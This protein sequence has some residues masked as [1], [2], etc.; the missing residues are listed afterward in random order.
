MNLRE[1]I[2]LIKNAQFPHTI[3]LGKNDI[4]AEGAKALAEQLKDAK[5][6]H[7]IYLERNNIGAEG[8]KALA[9]QLKDAKV[10]H[11]IG[12]SD[13]DI[14][15]EGA[16]ALVE[17]LKDAKVPLTISL[18]ENDIGAQGAKDLAEQWKDAK[19]PLTIYLNN[20]GAQG[21]KDLAEQWKDAKVSH[22]IGLRPNYTGTKGI[23][24][25][26]EQLKYAKVSH[27]IDLWDN[28]INYAEAKALREL[29]DAPIPQRI[30]GISEEVD[31]LNANYELER[32]FFQSSNEEFYAKNVL[33]WKF[34]QNF[35]EEIYKLFM[36]SF[37]SKYY[38]TI[39]KPRKNADGI[40][41]QNSKIPLLV[42]NGKENLLG[43][44]SNQPLGI[45][46]EYLGEHEIY[47]M[48]VELIKNMLIHMNGDF[49]TNFKELLEINKKPTTFKLFTSNKAIEAYKAGVKFEF[50]K[51]EFLALDQYDIAE[52]KQILSIQNY[53]GNLSNSNNIFI[54]FTI[55]TAI[56]N[57][58]ARRF[59]IC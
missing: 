6:S 53:L 7:N 16:K 1:A 12:L 31:K 25:L 43:I 27:T 48:N 47:R 17:Q 57:K 39:Y 14:G 42:L 26:A 59:I 18:I 13:N 11:N 46:G 34:C 52:H 22:T 33:E 5:V 23:K 8:A 49:D 24:D 58:Y 3:N 38:H 28:R 40:I 2:N 54:A 9:E 35:N 20:L 10:S 29:Y 32:K 41:I 56:E 30:L 50:Y 55:R 37:D 45:I 36:D 15:A 51:N 21:A 4:G 19:F 44:N